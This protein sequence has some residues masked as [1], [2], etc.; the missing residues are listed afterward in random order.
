M[1]PIDILVHFLITK[2][3]GEVMVGRVVFLIELFTGEHQGAG[4]ALDTG[5]IV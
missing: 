3:A 4:L 5:G 2:L 1:T